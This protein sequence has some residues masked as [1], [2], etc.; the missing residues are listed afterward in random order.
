MDGA[1]GPA[2]D[3]CASRADGEAVNQLGNPPNEGSEGRLLP[4]PEQAE[5]PRPAV[6]SAATVNIPRSWWCEHAI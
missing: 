2:T 5:S 6:R 3:A 1:A 4:A